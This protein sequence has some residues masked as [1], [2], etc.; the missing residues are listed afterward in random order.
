[1]KQVVQNE[2]LG[3][4]VYEESFWTGKKTVSVNGSQLEKISKNTFK[5]PD[6][7]TV[8]LKG[9]FF[10]GATLNVESESV[11]V[12]PPIKWY[13]IVLSVLPFILIMI[14]GTR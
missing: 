10:Q 3:E 2:K 6:G 13:E 11:R 12:T 7:E 14:W 9:N 1:M 8:E 4:I 5:T